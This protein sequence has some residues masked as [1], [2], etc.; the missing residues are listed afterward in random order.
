[1]KRSASPAFLKAMGDAVLVVDLAC[2][3]LI[4]AQVRVSASHRRALKDGQAR[5]AEEIFAATAQLHKARGAATVA[6][7]RLR[8]LLRY[9]RAR[10]RQ[11][12]AVN[13]K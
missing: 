2:G 7:S 10:E 8:A 1:V 12:L 9:T 4:D 13:R 3:A 6:R 11:R 5:A